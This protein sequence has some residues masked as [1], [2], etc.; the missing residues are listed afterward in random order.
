[1]LKI[2]LNALLSTLKILLIYLISHY[3]STKNKLKSAIRSAKLNYLRS[4]LSR[5]RQAPRFAA[6]LWSEVNDMVG[7]A[8]RQTPVLDSRLSLDDI[9][10][11]FGLLLSL[12]IIES[13]IVMLPCHFPMVGSCFNLSQWIAL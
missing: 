5:A 8:K 11:F 2:R 3:K 6:T 13:Q 12:P 1:M 10:Q 4:L 7:R 9:N